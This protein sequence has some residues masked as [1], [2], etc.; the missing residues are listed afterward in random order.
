MVMALAP[1]AELASLC[2][3]RE[4]SDGAVSYSTPHVEE[5]GGL[6]EF[7]PSVSGRDY[8][9][10]SWG[11]GSFYSYNLAEKAW[12]ALGLSPRCLGGDEQRTVYDDLSLPEFGVAEGEISTEYYFSPKRNVRWTVS[13][14]YLRRYLWMRGAYGVLVFV[15][16][17]STARRR[18]TAG[19]DGG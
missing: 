14:E 5:Q 13:N 16:R 12:M 15:L 18:R 17:S 7:K 9:A 1:P 19:T 4:A 10:A 2:L 11:N 6:G 3:L 8:I